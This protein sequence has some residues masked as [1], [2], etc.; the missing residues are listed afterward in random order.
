[1]FPVSY[2]N[3]HHKHVTTIKA[4]GF[5]QNV[6]NAVPV[7]TAK[8]KE[9][10]ETPTTVQFKQENISNY[11]LRF[12]RLV[13]F[14]FFIRESESSSSATRKQYDKIEILTSVIISSLIRSLFMF[15]DLVCAK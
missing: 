9:V 8:Q 1:M 2:V 13:V 7:V 15:H 6:Y 11:N 12:I 10:Q 14:S 5:H 4:K 3:S